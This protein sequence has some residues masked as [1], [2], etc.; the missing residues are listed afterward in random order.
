MKTNFK[1]IAIYISVFIISTVLVISANNVKNNL[2]VKKN[3]IKFLEKNLKNKKSQ[4][5]NIHSKLLKKKI[6]LENILFENGINFVNNSN[7][8]FNIG[9]E[10]Y[11]L[12]EFNSNDI[13]FAKHPAASSSAYIESSEDKIFLM[14]ATGQIV[15]TDIDDFEKESFNLKPIKTNIQKLIKYSEFFS[16][17]GFGVK[18]ILINKNDVYV[19]YIKEHYKDCFSLSI[20]K[21]RLDFDNLNFSDFYVPKECVN[22]NEKF[23]D[24]HEHDYL[25]AHQ[26]GG[27]LIINN[28]VLFF[29]TGDFRYRILAQ[30]KSRDVGKLVSINLDTN[31]KKI[32]SMGHRNPQGLYYHSNLNYLFSTEHGPNGGDEINLLNLNKKYSEIPNYG[33]PI[34]SYGRHYFDNDDD[35][36]VRYKLSPLNN[37]HAKYGFIEPIK[38]FNPSVGI[39]QIVGVD[40]KF[41]QTDGNVLFVGTMGTA[42][43]LKEGMISL[44]FFELM[45]DKIVKDQLIPV[46]S[47]VR[48]I[49]YHKENNYLVMYLETNNALAIFKKIN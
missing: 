31:E 3:Q 4:L 30:D 16:S 24:D 36:D 43:K 29:S 14:T 10:N 9:N 20:L 8:K 46:K 42:K 35:N 19:S 40:K 18:D 7:R 21:A 44:Y 49:I 11:L 13:V 48:D 2:E 45:D 28:N 22:K 15:Y 39:S 6:N 25:V 1:S 47:R 5:A 12:K 26:S 38:Y 41:Y 32:I 34:S 17:S 33:W 23:F 27:R 37:S